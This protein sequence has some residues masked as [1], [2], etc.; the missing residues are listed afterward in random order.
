MRTRSIPRPLLRFALLVGLAACGG[1]S[2]SDEPEHDGSL[3]TGDTGTD[4]GGTDACASEFSCGPAPE[5]ALA[6][7]PMETTTELGMPVAIAVMLSGSDGFGGEVGLSAEVV[8]GD[9][10][11]MVGWTVSLASTWVD[12]PTD[13][14]VDVVATVEVPTVNSGL[15]ARIRVTATSEAGNGSRSATARISVVD[16]YTVH[17]GVGELGGCVYPPAGITRLRVGSTVRWVND[18]T[19]PMSIHVS[20]NTDQCP[21]Q[22]DDPP[23]AQGEA[24]A[25]LLDGTNL[26]SFSWYCHTPG[27]TQAGLVFELVAP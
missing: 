5:L 22:A 17:V 16:R 12:L 4:D 2:G 21:H 25:C 11:P 24:Y 1:T 8:D 20:G 27:P 23:L 10:V 13:G 6:L 26:A 15:D 18:S 14:S 9:E 19:T 7:D 3:Q